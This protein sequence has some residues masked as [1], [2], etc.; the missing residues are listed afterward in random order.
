MNIIRPP[1]PDNLIKK[2]VRWWA[3]GY[4]LPYCLIR[5][6]KYNDAM[7]GVVVSN[8]KVRESPIKDYYVYNINSM[9]KYHKETFTIDNFFPVC[10]AYRIIIDGITADTLIRILEQVAVELKHADF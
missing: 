4:A 7:F 5:V 8:M 9:K 1:F 10:V 2:K 3:I 6:L